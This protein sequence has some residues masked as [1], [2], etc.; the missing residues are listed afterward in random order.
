MSLTIRDFSFVCKYSSFAGKC[1][2]HL[3]S[4]EEV[5]L[6][7][8]SGVSQSENFSNISRIFTKLYSFDFFGRQTNE[9]ND[10]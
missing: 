10:K 9:R 3:F 4:V 8:I 2:I 1:L 6:F 7:Y 5:T